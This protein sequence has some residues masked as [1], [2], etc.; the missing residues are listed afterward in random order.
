MS[1]T[2]AI[3]KLKIGMYIHLELGWLAHPFPLSSFRIESADEIDK[4]RALGVRELRW[5]PEKSLLGP[6]AAPPAGNAAADAAGAAE[7]TAAEADPQ[8]RALAHQRECALRCDRQYTEAAGSL[9][10]LMGLVRTDPEAAH[11]QCQALTRA[12]LSK[13]LGQGEMC[14]LVLSSN[15][16]EKPA[17]HPLNVAVVSLLMAQQF[18]MSEQEMHA[19]GMAALLHDLGKIDL[20]DRVHHNDDRLSSGELSAYRDHV[21]L[22]VV[23][24]QRM[25]LP[26]DVLAMI[27]QHHEHADGSGFPQRL[28]AER[29]SIGARLIA[30]VNRFDNLCNPRHAARALTPHEALSRLF[31]QHRGKFDA[32][33][34]NAFIRMM[35]VYPAG[36]IV[37]LTDDRFAS[38]MQVNSSRPLKPRV[39]VHDE[40]VPRE[41]ALLLNLAEEREL[42]IRRSLPSAQ[43]PDAVREYLNPVRR[44]AYFFDS[45]ANLAAPAAPMTGWGTASAAA[46]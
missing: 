41:R 5:S 45:V 37:Q 10:E 20:P 32:T 12:M 25:G 3:D 46:A 44:L 23:H 38:V 22:G 17:A 8:A 33:I 18:G 19:I 13:M 34:L 28:V 11:H 29:L 9:R 40:R 36:S 26:Q 1:D 15:A 35:G 6:A 16:G 42:G 27:A 43:L 21:R 24:G 14:I 2:V 30:L 4:L 7:D 31:T 39:L